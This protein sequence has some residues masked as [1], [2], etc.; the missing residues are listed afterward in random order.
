MIREWLDQLDE[1]LLEKL[2]HTGAQ[3]AGPGGSTS[4]KDAE[5]CQEA[6][7]QVLHQGAESAAASDL[8]QASGLPAGHPRKMGRSFPR[9]TEV[10]WVLVCWFMIGEAHAVPCQ[11]P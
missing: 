2:R 11:G 3:A 5:G 1:Q 9:V 6:R 4:K 8:A 10:P 7:S